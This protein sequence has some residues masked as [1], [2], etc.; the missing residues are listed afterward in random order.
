MGFVERVE[1]FKRRKGE[2]DAYALGEGGEE[3]AVEVG[4]GAEQSREGKVVPMLAVKSLVEDGERRWIKDFES[5][6]SRVE[7]VGRV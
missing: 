6:L 2:V 1:R 3:Q 7:R 5:R 4:S